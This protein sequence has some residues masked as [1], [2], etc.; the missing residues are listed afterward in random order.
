MMHRMTGTPTPSHNVRRSKA[1]HAYMS[2][3]IAVGPHQPNA[4]CFLVPV[5][6]C[7]NPT[8]DAVLVTVVADTHGG[9]DAEAEP[10]TRPRP[11]SGRT[12]PESG[13][14]PVYELALVR[15][16]EVVYDD[17]LGYAGVCRFSTLG[18]AVAEL[19]QVGAGLP[20]L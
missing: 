1:A 20:D 3:H 2:R 10:H 18:A 5:P 16:G 19:V 15:S 13:P 4:A 8:V 6:Y 7:P 9:A 14:P 11:D 17:I 12:R